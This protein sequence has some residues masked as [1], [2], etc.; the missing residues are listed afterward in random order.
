[1]DRLEQ[2]LVLIAQRAWVARQLVAEALAARVMDI[3]Y[4]NSKNSITD[5]AFHDAAMEV[6]G[7]MHRLQ[8]R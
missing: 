3:A 4:P 1:L 6:W 2:L 8:Q 7:V 5:R